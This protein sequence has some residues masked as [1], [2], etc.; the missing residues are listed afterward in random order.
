MRITVIRK[1]ITVRRL[2]VRISPIMYISIVY[3]VECWP[4]WALNRS[5]SE[6]NICS[7]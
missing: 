2:H 5:L 1:R 7:R 6:I 3:V 4:E